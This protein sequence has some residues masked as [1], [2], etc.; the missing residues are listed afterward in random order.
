MQLAS[1]SGQGTATIAVN[2]SANNAAAARSG[3]IVV[4][5][6]RIQLSQE[7]RGCT[8]TLS[9]ATDPVPAAG[10][11]RSLQIATLQECPWTIAT[12]APSWLQATVTSGS[13]PATVA[14]DV[15]ANSGNA[16]EASL[17]VGTRSFIVSMSG[18][19]LKRA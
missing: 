11:R 2:V 6:Q 4:N 17:T 3:A 13:G 8:I 19:L 5:D 15:Q 9:G 12:S 7:G 1:T 10:G 18:S 16:R 14:Y